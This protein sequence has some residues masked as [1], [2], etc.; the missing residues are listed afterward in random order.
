MAEFNR[1]YTTF[2]QSAIVRIDVVFYFFELFDVEAYR[3]QVRVT[4]GH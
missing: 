4:Q 2:Y 1:S 3:D